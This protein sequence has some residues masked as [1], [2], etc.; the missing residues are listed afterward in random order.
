MTHF[1]ADHFYTPK[2]YG[3]VEFTPPEEM[4]EDL[5]GELKPV[6]TGQHMLEILKAEEREEIE[7]GAIVLLSQADGE[8]T[9][10]PSTEPAYFIKENVTPADVIAMLSKSISPDSNTTL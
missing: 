6:L 10:T 5:K 2:P 8:E 3:F 7:P 9:I 4:A 1:D